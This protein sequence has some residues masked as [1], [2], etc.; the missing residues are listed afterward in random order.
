MTFLAPLALVALLV[1]PI[2]Y[3]IHF[4]RGSRRQRRV[5][6]IFL[7]AD[8]PPTP[9]GRTQRRWPPF[10]L[11]LVLQL[12]A[13]VV[14]ALALARPA[15]VGEPPKHVALVLDTSGSMQATDVAPSR[16]AAARAEALDQLRRLGDGDRASVVLAGPTPALAATG[17]PD[18]VRS[19]LTNSQPTN[20]SAALR[21]ALALASS[22][23]ASTPDRQGR[24]VLLTDGA[25]PGVES[26]GTLAAPLDIASVGGGSENQAV[27]SL[28]VRLDPAGNGQAAL[29]EVANYADHGV[30]AP[31]RLLADGAVL[32]ERQVDLPARGRARVA[33]PLPVDAQRIGVRLLGQDALA[34]DDMGETITPGGQPHDVVLIARSGPAA[35]GTATPLRR[36]LE[37]LPFVHIKAADQGS[38]TPG[39]LSVVDGP[40][41]AQLPQA[42]LLLVNPSVSDP[43]LAG[44]GEH[45]SARPAVA[46][47]LLEGVDTTALRGVTP[48]LAGPPAWAS[49][50]LG[51]QDGPLVIEG[52][53][54]GRRVVAFTFDPLASGLD[55]SLSFPL[56]VSNATGYLLSQAG[57]PQ[58]E[59]FD[60]TESDIRP[61][62][63]PALASTGGSPRSEV[64]PVDRWA[65]LV[66]GLVGLLGL[67]WLVFARRG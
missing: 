41:P 7:W 31:L 30:R 12:A 16:F 6:A 50:V 14:A 15:T 27:A 36:A 39:D 32:D 13:A 66:V 1:A 28:Q 23:V 22:Q 20:G 64:F 2:V 59:P 9:T 51:N 40:I 61:R 37:A 45:S 26:L 56:L 43:R 46:H 62:P 4:L 63:V 65:W 44:R 3:L 53:L 19:A 52:R 57:A 35:G 29:V 33:I 24:I 60:P 5:P 34:A 48:S 10:T 17:T 25:A 58:S 49:V 8:L 55:K 47:P 42:P 18:Q 38:Q 11:L 67:E 21:E 54:E